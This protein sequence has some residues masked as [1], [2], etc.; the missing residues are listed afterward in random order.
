MHEI[1][2]VGSRHQDETGQAAEIGDIEGAGM[3][4]SIG[5]DQT[6][7]IHGETHRQPLDGDVVH[8]LVIGALQERRIDRRERLE[9]LGRQ[10]CGEGHAMLLGNA[11]VEGAVRETLSGTDRCRCPTASPR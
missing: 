7:A 5:A 8:D 10:T 3:G 11:D 9:A 2:L 6:G 4:R 1:G